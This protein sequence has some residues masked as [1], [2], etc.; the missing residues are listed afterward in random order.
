[1]DRRD[2]L[3]PDLETAVAAAAVLALLVIVAWLCARILRRAGLPGWLALFVLV[4]GWNLL[5]VWVFAFVPWPVEG[6]R[7]A[8]LQSIL[9]MGSRDRPPSRPE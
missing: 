1:M 6:A 8:L 3:I 4:P 9:R 2:A 5:A 7:R